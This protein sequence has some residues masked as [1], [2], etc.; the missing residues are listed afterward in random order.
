MK[1]YYSA[2]NA[3]RKNAIYTLF[4]LPGLLYII[5]NNY[6]PMAGIFIA[7]K[8]INYR[9]G[10]FGSPWVGMD[11]FQFLFRSK[12]A[13][14]MIRNTLLYNLSF[15]V[16]GTVFAVIIA[17]QLCELRGSRSA[18]IFQGSLIIPHLLSWIIV[19]Y[20]VY[21]FL[22]SDTGFLNNS[23]LKKLGLPTNNWYGDNHAWPVIIPIVYLWKSAGYSSIVYM[24]SISGIDPALF[25]AAKIDGAGKLRQIFYITLPLIRPTVIIMTLMAIGGIFYS[26]FG[27]FYQVPMNSGLLYAST[28]TIDTYVYRALIKLGSI[29]MSS[30]AGV[31][32]SVMGFV[33]VLTANLIVRKID[34]D[35]SLF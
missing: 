4:L 13:G 25:E 29:E 15:I 26:D 3:V 7:F 35:N 1:K 14:I 33:V 6:V 16:L 23:V 9:D 31:M 5:L 10:I 22:S 32:Q 2:S 17:I 30:A 18:K 12:D 34:P 21:S 28:Q 20:I 24:A 8:K 19:S 11:N 27:L